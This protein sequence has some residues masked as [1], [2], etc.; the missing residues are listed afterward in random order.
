MEL[1]SETRDGSDL[2]PLELQEALATI[3]KFYY[4]SAGYFDVEVL[5]SSNKQAIIR[6]ERRYSSQVDHLILRHVV[7]LRACFTFQLS[8]YN[9]TLLSFVQTLKTSPYLHSMSTSRDFY[10]KY[11]SELK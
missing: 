10:S 4:G 7:Q 6:V 5:S 8:V 2:N 9:D 1:I 3:I 11:L